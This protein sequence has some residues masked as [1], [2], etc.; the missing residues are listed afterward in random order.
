MCIASHI[1]STQ[2]VWSISVKSDDDEATLDR[3]AMLRLLCRCAEAGHSSPAALASAAHTLLFLLYK[4]P[5][6]TLADFAAGRVSHCNLTLW[7]LL[8]LMLH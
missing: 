1:F 5:D 6:R 7:C 8:H 2:S 4:I 3:R